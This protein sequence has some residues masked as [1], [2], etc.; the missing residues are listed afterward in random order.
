ME[1]ARE[2]ALAIARFTGGAVAVSGKE[3]LVTDGHFVAY[4]KGGSELMN[5]V[6]GFGCS[7]GGVCAVYATQTTPFVAALAAVAHYNAAGT[8]A[9]VRAQAPASFKVAFID[10]LYRLTAEEI[11]Q[12]PLRVEEA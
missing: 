7:L 10:E 5:K 3:D 4:S 11:S 2:A 9:R 12:N 6:T 1:A 8:R